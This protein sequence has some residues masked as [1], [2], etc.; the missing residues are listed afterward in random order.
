[1][2]IQLLPASEIDQLK[3]NS[4][5]HYATHPSF[6][7]Y[8]WYLNAYSKDWVGLVEGDYESVMPLF[9][10]KDWLGRTVYNQ[11]RHIAPTGPFSIHVIS[12]P[13]ILSFLKSMPDRVQDALL[14]WEGQIGLPEIT[15]IQEERYLL[16]LYGPYTDL[17]K[18]FTWKEDAPYIEWSMIQ[19][20]PEA[21]VDFWKENTPRY[22]QKGKDYH[23]YL[24]IMYQAMHRGLGFMTGIGR[25]TDQL[26]AAAFFISSGGVL[27][28]LLSAS[29]PGSKGMEANR[30][31]IDLMIQTHAGRPLILDLKNDPQ[32]ASFGA[33]RLQYT[34]VSN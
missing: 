12:R 9:F 2:D 3:W 27:Y 5:V 11:P 19:L 24:R 26:E 14:P 28:R 31:M 33:T 15:D 22:R 23:R 4:C 17:E 13:R 32:A 29:L 6:S 7:G 10:Q 20:Q 1:M 21:M 25:D 16:H 30:A 18:A 8:T 34:R